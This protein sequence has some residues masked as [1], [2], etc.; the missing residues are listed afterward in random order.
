MSPGVFRESADGD[1]EK[2]RTVNLDVGDAD[3]CQSVDTGSGG[4]RGRSTQNSL[5]IKLELCYGGYHSVEV[6]KLTPLVRS[7]PMMTLENEDTRT[8]KLVKSV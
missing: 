1:G 4:T 6:V 2:K 8:A 3:C 5:E 7:P